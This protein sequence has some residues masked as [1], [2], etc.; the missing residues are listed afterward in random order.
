[1]LDT[2]Q[3]SQ[4]E[5]GE[6]R[7][8]VMNYTDYYFFFWNYYRR[9]WFLVWVKSMHNPKIFQKIVV[10]S[11]KKALAHFFWAIWWTYKLAEHFSGEI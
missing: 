8:S 11:K 4:K 5:G 2:C 10:R 1:M 3:N 9:K 7:L 6:G